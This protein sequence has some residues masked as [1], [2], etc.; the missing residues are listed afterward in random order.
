MS[1][2]L[3]SHGT[4]IC[5][6][7]KSGVLLHRT[8]TANFDDVDV[9]EVDDALQVLSPNFG[10]YMRDDVSALRL[11]LDRGFLAGW[12]ITRSPDQRSL[13]LSR[14][15]QWLKTEADTGTVGLTSDG[16]LEAARFLPVSQPDLAVL[17]DMLAGQWLVQ[18]AGAGVPPQSG[19]LMPGFTLSVGP[20]AIDLRWNL[21]FDRSEWPHRLAVLQDGWRISQIYR[22]RPLI[23]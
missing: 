16:T 6:D 10:H 13:M 8:L 19:R 21:P 2:L 18:S 15:G 22:Y 12:T 9:L 14:Y 5:R 11:L 4:L 3:S 1:R 17:A 20:L 7:R 23:Y